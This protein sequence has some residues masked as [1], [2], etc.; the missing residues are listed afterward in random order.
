MKGEEEGEER[1]RKEGERGREEEKKWNEGGKKESKKKLSSLRPDSKCSGFGS[2]GPF[3]P[4]GS[5][6]STTGPDSRP[7]FTTEFFRT[8]VCLSL[9]WPSISLDA[10]SPFS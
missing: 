1:Q 2:S 7:E 9:A 3:L 6:L 4:S 8:N 5:P 10:L